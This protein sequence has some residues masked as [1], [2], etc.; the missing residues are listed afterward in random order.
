MGP[1]LQSFQASL[2]GLTDSPSTRNPSHTYPGTGLNRTAVIEPL[3]KDSGQPPVQVLN[4]GLKVS[5]II[6]ETLKVNSNTNRVIGM[7]SRGRAPPP[8]DW[9]YIWA[10][11]AQG[12]GGCSTGRG[13]VPSLRKALGSSAPRAHPHGASPLLGCLSSIPPRPPTHRISGVQG[14][15]FAVGKNLHQLKDLLVDLGDLA[16]QDA[17]PHAPELDLLQLQKLNGCF[18]K[19]LA[20]E[21]P[22]RLVSPPS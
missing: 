7:K 16:A 19:I 2:R 4:F 17:A 5:V 20:E 11:Q 22:A 21:T 14:V 6:I 3:A 12:R 18:I 1:A 15:I 10:G 13:F 8:Q 9:G